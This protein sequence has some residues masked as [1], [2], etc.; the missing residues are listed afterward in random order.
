MV[1]ELF[2]PATFRGTHHPFIQCLIVMS[3]DIHKFAL[4]SRRSEYLYCELFHTIII[5]QSKYVLS[6]KNVVVDFEK[7]LLNS[8]KYQFPK[9][10]IIG[11]YFHM[12]Q[13]IFRRIKKDGN[14][15]DEAQIALNMMRSW[16]SIDDDPINEKLQKI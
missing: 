2:I 4:T 11:C 1:S 10:R 8:V 14:P 5:V 15:D 9:S 6:Q 16:P 12:R 7:A 13:E 3:F